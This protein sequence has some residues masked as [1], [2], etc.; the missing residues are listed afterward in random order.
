MTWL[1]VFSPFVPYFDLFVLDEQLLLV[2][3]SIFVPGFLKLLL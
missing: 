3:E 2:V 1:D